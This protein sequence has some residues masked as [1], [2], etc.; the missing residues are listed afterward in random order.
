MAACP[1]AMQRPQ[2]LAD[3]TFPEG[4]SAVLV[5]ARR[6]LVDRR[7]ARAAYEGREDAGRAPA[8]ARF[9]I[10]ALA[11]RSGRTKQF[12]RAARGG[13]ARRDHVYRP[14]VHQVARCRSRSHHRDR[15]ARNLRDRRTR[16]F[17]RPVLAAAAGVIIVV[18]LR[19]A[20]AAARSRAR[21]RALRP[22]TARCRAAGRPRLS[23]C[24][25][26]LPDASHRSLARGQSAARLEAHGAHHAGRCRAGYVAQ[27]L[28]GARAGL[29]ISGLLGGF[30]S[31]TAVVATMGKRAQW[32]S[33][34]YCQQRSRSGAVEMSPRWCS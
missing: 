4:A 11:R 1:H 28:V 5:G 15:A 17:V 27:R 16:R 26:I 32:R 6:R 21:R 10:T 19:L 14:L 12:R 9:A 34:R 33:R 31:S 2:S 24:C 7:R 20:R 25:H 23:W 30:V 3:W 13:R 29:P 8:C 18:L 22:G